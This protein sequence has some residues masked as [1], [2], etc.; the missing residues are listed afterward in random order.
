MVHF[1]VAKCGYVHFAYDMLNVVYDLPFPD[2]KLY[3]E[4]EELIKEDQMLTI[5]NK[6][7]GYRP[8]AEWPAG[9]PRRM[10]ALIASRL[11][12]RRLSVVLDYLNYRTHRNHPKFA[13]YYHYSR[14]VMATQPVVIKAIDV[15]LGQSRSEMEPEL[16]ADY[17]VYKAWLLATVKDFGRAN[18]LVEEAKDVA[19]EYAWVYVQESDI[20]EKQDRYE[21]A[22]R[23]V[24]YAL[25]LRPLYHAA[26]LRKETAL[27]QL[28]RDD[29]AME[30]LMRANARAEHGVYGLRLQHLYSERE[31]HEKMLWALGEYERFS[32][33]LP[34]KSKEWLSGRRGDCYYLAGNYESA[35][36][37]YSKF[38]KGFYKTVHGHL[39]KNI[40]GAHRRIKLDVPFVRQHDMTCAPATLASLSK[41]YGKEHDHL[42]IAEAICYDGTPWH[43]ERTWAE[44]NGFSVFEFRFTEEV[45][46]VLIDRE[47]PFT[48]STHA[49]TSAH[50]QACIGYDSRLGLA[51]IRDPT[52]RH[53]GEMLFED[54]VREHPVF[55]PRGMLFV[56][57]EELD[58][59]EGI[60]FPDQTIYDERHA[61]MLA[62]DAHDEFK[63]ME[64]ISTL[65]A[66]GG[67]HALVIDSEM[68]LERY[69]S[70]HVRVHELC[71]MLHERFPD[72]E[73]I[74]LDYFY[75]SKWRYGRGKQLEIGLNTVA[76][77]GA[78]PIFYAELGDL[79]LEDLR[80]IEIAE[81]YL[82]KSAKCTFSNARSMAGLALCS[83]RKGELDDALDFKRYASCQSPSWEAYAYQYFMMALEVSRE[84]EAL[85]FLEARTRDLGKSSSAPWVTLSRAY[86]EI[87]DD[88]SS[89]RVAKRALELFPE[90][91]DLMVHLAM[92]SHSWGEGEQA[93]AYISKAKVHLSDEDWHFACGNLERILG[94]RLKALRHFKRVTEL[95][96]MHYSGQRRYC[97]LLEEEYGSGYVLNYLKSLI[98]EHGES[99]ILLEIYAVKL[100]ELNDERLEVVLRKILNLDPHNLW[101]MREL[102]LRREESGDLD[103]A[104]RLARLCVEKQPNK[105]ESHGVLG[106]VYIRNGML[107]EGKESFKEAILIDAD[108]TFA[109]TEWLDSLEYGDDKLEVLEF[110][111]EQLEVQSVQGEALCEYRKLAY[112]YVQPDL[113]LDHVRGFRRRR[114]CEWSAWVAE[115]DQL[116]DMDRLDEAEQLIDEAVVKFPHIPRMYVEKASVHKAMG[117]NKGNIESLEKALEYSP[118]WDWVGRAL[119]DAYELDGDLVSAEKVLRKTMQWAPLNPANGG[120]LSKLLDNSGRKEEAFSLLAEVLERSPMYDW[121][122]R[123]LSSWAVDMKREGEVL[124]LLD[125]HIDKRSELSGWWEV[126]FDVYD[127]LNKY[128][129]ALEYCES[130]LQKDSRNIEVHDSK[131]YMLSKLGRVEEAIAAALPEVFGDAVPPR[132]LSRRALIVYHYVGPRQGLELMEKL[133]KTF[134][135]FVPAYRNL[136]EWYYLLGDHSASEKYTKQ[137]LRLEPQSF[138]A[139][140]H[141]GLLSEIRKRSDV[142]ASYYEKAFQINPEYAHAGYRAFE[143][144]LESKRLEVLPK[145][146]QLTS[147]YG[148][149][150]ESLEMSVRYEHALGDE[151]EAFRYFTE[152]IERDDL[153]VEE[154]GKTIDLFPNKGR[155]HVLEIVESGR[156]QSA[157]LLQA[158]LW[159]RSSVVHTAKVAVDLPYPREVKY[160]LWKD[161]LEWLSSTEI[162][163]SDIKLFKDDF[164]TEFAENKE[165]LAVFLRACVIFDQYAIGCD[166]ADDLKRMDGVEDWMLANAAYCEIAERGVASSQATIERGIQLRSGNGMNHLLAMSAILAAGGGDIEGAEEALAQRDED[167][168]QGAKSLGH[169]AKMFIT[170]MQGDQ[171]TQKVYWYQFKNVTEGWQQDKYYKSVMSFCSE[172]AAKNGKKWLGKLSLLKSIGLNR[173]SW[174][175]L[176][177]VYL[178]IKLLVALLD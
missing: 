155:K 87:H 15:I 50:L 93:E 38:E 119:A 52:N 141:L 135:D 13:L 106:G 37:C 132:L 116:L 3:E 164:Y 73:G 140:G 9:E 17:L 103:E 44:S 102:A 4:L 71:M 142:A 130:F 19:P 83:Y 56:P 95:N 18:I 144:N 43:K 84:G 89:R 62:L 178:L 98:S 152:L 86:E 177:V 167:M 125:C 145:V 70:N 163:E 8:L 82:K 10:A 134:P 32:P 143:L 51:I 25:R 36:E 88:E 128:D 45:T 91:G 30:L 110:Y 100:S 14:L 12:D 121:G 150:T 124:D 104:I 158:W 92:S 26:I 172:V 173:L 16:L 69:R 1:A 101:A 64:A 35:L 27:I 171:D 23:A 21:E 136:S 53:Y 77:E 149:Y 131:A 90:D 97:D 11:G 166:V 129:S 113:L 34:D 6:I 146:I 33:M 161:L 72:S 108:Y 156:A 160:P 122:W 39:K 133:V 68:R 58:K 29:E 61:L 59:V 55:G 28:N 127:I 154:I 24:D 168:D 126:C 78:D 162:Y 96:V 80:D 170:C 66:I 63:M 79:Y 105:C 20:L 159:G 42:E 147:H 40:E 65:R 112:K 5:W 148:R 175:H 67:E 94:D 111:R 107:E 114:G 157:G 165:C 54:L 46:K 85:A 2:G 47:L 115:K 99:L 7:E 138:M 22:N 31:D 151:P 120:S 76:K 169:L 48:L 41:Y 153:L 174:W 109:L 57:E 117:D 123:E 75:S 60:D 118:S 176:A 139:Y 81:F 74:A 49:V 137:W